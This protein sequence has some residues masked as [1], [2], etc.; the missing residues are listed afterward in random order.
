MFAL[1]VAVTK[2]RLKCAMAL[3][4]TS[5]FLALPAAM[6]PMALSMVPLSCK[7]KGGGMNSRYSEWEREEV[8]RGGGGA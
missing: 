2:S 5:S 1:D 7:G 8:R 6:S 4:S 3:S